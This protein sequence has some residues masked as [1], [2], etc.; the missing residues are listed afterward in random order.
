M[1]IIY[2]ILQ[3]KNLGDLN[4]ELSLSESELEVINSIS[5]DINISTLVTFWQFILKG[6]EE[7]SIVTNQIL[8]L[9]MI[10]MRLIHLK[11][12]PSYEAVLDLVNKNNLTSSRDDNYITNNKQIETTGEKRE[13]SKS[14]KNQI[15]NTTQTKLKVEALSQSN[16]RN[17]HK[18]SIS[19][20]EGLIDLSSEKKEIELKYDL[21]RNV[22]LI[23]FSQGKIDIG[24]NENLNKNFVRNLSEKLLE[25]TGSRWIISLTKGPGKISFLEQKAINRKKLLEQ[26]RKND[27]YK[28]FK[29]IF[30]DSEL[31]DVKK[32]D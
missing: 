2:F 18:E 7:L 23:K 27:I 10:I 8:S 13:I 14:A 21:E 29:N 20:L 4:S 17:L 9:E 15:K 31:I 26:E 24:F 22:N 30:S 28:K 11:D 12:M 1:E 6:I 32:K 25:W 16:T 19:S 5:K 3:K